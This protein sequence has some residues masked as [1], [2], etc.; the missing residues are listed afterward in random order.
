LVS[1]TADVQEVLNLTHKFTPGR[2]N[3]SKLEPSWNIV[4]YN[5]QLLTAL[6]PPED[7]RH[8]VSALAHGAF[9]SGMQGIY[10]NLKYVSGY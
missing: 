4:A 7:S 2:S 5:P 10:S 8:T 1:H 6:V 9:K 3:V